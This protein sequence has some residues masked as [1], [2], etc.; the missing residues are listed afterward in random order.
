MKR[1][2]GILLPVFSLYDDYGIGSFSKYA[3]SF[4]DFLAE[5]AQTYWQVL[6]IGP[7]SFGNSPYQAYSTFAIEPLFIDVD[8]LI[9][10]GLLKKNDITPISVKGNKIDYEETKAYKYPLYLKAF[11][12]FKT[13]GDKS[14][15]SLFLQEES[16]WIEGYADFMV[17]HDGKDAYPADFYKFL[18]F[19]ALK[20][21][22]K[23]K[24]YANE[25][26]VQIIGDIPIYVSPDSAEVKQNP[27]LFML[28]EKRER[29]LI[30]GCPGDGYAPD[31]QL[32]GNPLYDWE[33]HKKTGFA[34]W[35]KRIQKVLSL[36]DVVRIDHFRGLDEF[37]AIPIEDENAHRGRWLPGPGMDLFNALRNALGEVPLIAEDLGFLTDSVRKLLADSG[38]PG[39][40]VL[41]FG[42]GS[43]PYNEYLPHLYHHN[44]V[45]YTGTHDNMTVYGWLSEMDED[46][47]EHVK[48]YLDITPNQDV[49]LRELARHF[50]I[51]AHSCVADT[52]IIPIQDYLYLGNDARIN[53][54]STLGEEN[55]T[56]HLK[57]DSLPRNLSAEIRNITKRYAR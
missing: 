55:W 43:G 30:A 49:T 56:W 35:I 10:D 17:A 34:W 7:V 14:P 2:A 42:F 40:K 18:Q 41:Q 1:A 48:E 19:Y 5:G 54:P 45:V 4:V 27:E 31:G 23:V 33:Y 11:E 29:E 22:K 36:Y 21:W 6:P 46:T 12:N 20:Q 9:E 38:Y 28:N 53:T 15:M 37:F 24:A 13:S 51:L 8:G 39:M 25:K 50:I 44:S 16:D 32:W 47:L 26:G 57:K 52:C 3:Y